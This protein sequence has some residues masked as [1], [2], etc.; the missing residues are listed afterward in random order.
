MDQN[1]AEIHPKKTSQQFLISPWV[2]SF[3]AS[4]HPLKRYTPREHEGLLKAS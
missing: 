2:C 4:Y 1:V 3:Q